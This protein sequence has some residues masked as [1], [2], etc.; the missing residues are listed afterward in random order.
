MGLH[1]SA[2]GLHSGVDRTSPQN[3]PLSFVWAGIQSPTTLPQGAQS[4]MIKST[5]RIPRELQLQAAQLHQYPLG[6]L[7]GAAKKHKAHSLLMVMPRT[8]MT[9]RSVSPRTVGDEMMQDLRNRCSPRWAV[10]RVIT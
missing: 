8:P 7:D 9:P 2:I 6:S 10:M 5:C 4:F 1:Q 3:H